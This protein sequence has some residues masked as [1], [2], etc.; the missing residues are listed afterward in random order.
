MWSYFLATHATHK[1]DFYV[2]LLDF[3]NAL[4]TKIKNTQKLPRVKEWERF[5]NEKKIK[6][7]LKIYV[8]NMLKN[9]NSQSWNPYT[10]YALTKIHCLVNSFCQIFFFFFFQFIYVSDFDLC[11]VHVNRFF[12]HWILLR[13]Y[14]NEKKTTTTTTKEK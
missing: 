5:E 2:D 4:H 11:V 6:D 14:N 12:F 8:E 9:R 3:L 10:C 7:R 1:M 13:T